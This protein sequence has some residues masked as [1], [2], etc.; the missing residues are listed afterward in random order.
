[1]PLAKSIRFWALL[2]P[3]FFGWLAFLPAPAEAS[4]FCVTIDG[5]R[6]PLCHYEDLDECRRDAARQKGW[7]SV[8]TKEF[9]NLPDTGSRV[10]L[11]ETSRVVRCLYVDMPSCQ[12]DANRSEGVCFFRP[13]RAPRQVVP[14]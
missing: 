11:M 1:M 14:K 8:N 6:T 7:C 10:C 2:L 12:L 9:R 13:Y 5:V 4:P 3:I